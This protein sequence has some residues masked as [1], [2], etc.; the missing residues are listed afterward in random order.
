MRGT[1]TLASSAQHRP[2]TCSPIASIHCDV[3]GQCSS[4]RCK[5]SETNQSV[6]DHYTSPASDRNAQETVGSGWVSQSSRIPRS[7]SKVLFGASPHF[8]VIRSRD[9]LR[10]HYV[11]MKRKPLSRVSDAFSSPSKK[12]NVG[13]WFFIEPN[14]TQTSGEYIRH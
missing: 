3:C 7:R 2:R 10:R 11:L 13:Q 12:C 8:F 9:S 5:F 4:R 1:H 6:W 14:R